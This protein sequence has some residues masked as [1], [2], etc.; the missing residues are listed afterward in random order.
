M[1]LQE[2]T[3]TLVETVRKTLFK[4][5]AVD[6]RGGRWGSISNTTWTSADLSPWNRVRGSVGGD[7]F[8]EDI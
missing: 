4:T 2:I 5:I 7:V 1:I 8:I 6:G 3:V